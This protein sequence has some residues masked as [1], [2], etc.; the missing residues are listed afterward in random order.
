MFIKKFSKKE[1]IIVTHFETLLLLDS[2]IT[3]NEDITDINAV[4]KDVYDLC[5]GK[6]I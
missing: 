4:S 3:R 1:L 2:E 6:M 5:F